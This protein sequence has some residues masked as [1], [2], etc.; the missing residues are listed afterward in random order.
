MIVYAPYQYTC[1]WKF[2]NLTFNLVTIPISLEINRICLNKLM[3]PENFK[4]KSKS[5]FCIG[6]GDG[7]KR[8]SKKTKRGKKYSNSKIPN[9]PHFV[10]RLWMHENVPIRGERCLQETPE[11]RT[12]SISM[13]ASLLLIFRV[14][15]SGS[16]LSIMIVL[17]RT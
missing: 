12:L 16:C 15:I 13:I 5:S 9:L 2:N 14:R 7:K 11:R 6:F 1:T 17:N 4:K 10:R 3:K 8:K